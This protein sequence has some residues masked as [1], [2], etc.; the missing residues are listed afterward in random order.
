MEGKSIGIQSLVTRAKAVEPHLPEGIV[1]SN[2]YEIRGRNGPWCFLAQQDTP[3]SGS[4]NTISNPTTTTDLLTSPTMSRARG[5]RASWLSLCFS[6]GLI[7]RLLSTRDPKV[8]IAEGCAGR[9]RDMETVKGNNVA[10]LSRRVTS[11]PGLTAFD[12]ET[13]GRKWVWKSAEPQ[14]WRKIVWKWVAEPLIRLIS[15]RRHVRIGPCPSIVCCDQR[16][17]DLCKGIRE[18]HGC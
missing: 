3:C 18:L 8:K 15:P 7:Y 4:A 10:R 12:V 17:I 1:R 5:V 13:V 2:Y 9:S 11:S 16:D 14:T 6:Q